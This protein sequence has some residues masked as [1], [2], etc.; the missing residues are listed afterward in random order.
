[1]DGDTICL[2]QAQ[3]AELFQSSKSNISEH[4]KHVIKEGEL[5]K[6]LVVANLE[7]LEQLNFNTNVTYVTKK[8]M[9]ERVEKGF[10]KG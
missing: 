6:S 5:K 9:M 2:G 1:M 10:G 3:M 7:Q 4:I 8:E